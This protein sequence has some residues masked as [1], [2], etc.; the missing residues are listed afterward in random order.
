MDGSHKSYDSSYTLST[1]HTVLGWTPPHEQPDSKPGPQSTK[2]LS[3]VPPDDTLYLRPHVRDSPQTRS[4]LRP[5][6]SSPRSSL[7]W[8]QQHSKTMPVPSI[9]MKSPKHP[10]S[11]AESVKSPPYAITA[12]QGSLPCIHR[13]PSH[14]P[15]LIPAGIFCNDSLAVGVESPVTTKIANQKLPEINSESRWRDSQ[16]ASSVGSNE[17]C[18]LCLHRKQPCD[19]EQS[20][21]S[22]IFV[23]CSMCQTRRP[24]TIPRIEESVVFCPICSTR[25]PSYAT[26]RKPSTVS[27]MCSI[28]SIRRSS[29][30]NIDRSKKECP[31]C[32]LFQPPPPENGD[33]LCSTCLALQPSTPAEK[34]KERPS[35]TQLR[36][37]A[38]HSRPSCKK[39]KQHIAAPSYGV[40][41]HDVV[42]EPIKRPTNTQ[43]KAQ[44]L[45]TNASNPSK[46]DYLND[47]MHSPLPPV[48]IDI[49]NNQKER[50]SDHGFPITLASTSST[51]ELHRS[52]PKAST[53]A[54]FRG[55]QVATNAA[56][57]E[58]ID[59]WVFEVTGKRVRDFLAG[60]SILE[61][62]GASALAGVAK[63][64]AKQ[65][66]EEVRIL[67]E[68]RRINIEDES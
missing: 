42:P 4:A 22:R 48:P 60:L 62:I 7:P 3:R 24:S 44:S 28:C 16:P 47:K 34:E 49:V 55:L 19:M 17:M 68:M 65:R 14:D 63:R 18:S 46:K 20:S 38:L 45:S 52:K 12:T 31:W 61:G 58:D 30:V 10:S 23:V 54:V 53:K 32:L 5:A 51:L 67:E 11:P 50:D 1:D 66:R 29:V 2:N 13:Q 40:L 39:V 8:L 41:N 64:A 27:V 43:S 15:T 9:S 37:E 25:Q 35:P 36:E 57:D 33:M 6:Q 21:H 26:N 56:C 59:Q